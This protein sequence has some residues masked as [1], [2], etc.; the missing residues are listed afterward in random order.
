MLT[1]A[2][3]PHVRRPRERF[4]ISAAIL[5]RRHN[6]PRPPRGGWIGGTAHPFPGRPAKIVSGGKKSRVLQSCA[7]ALKAALNGLPAQLQRRCALMVKFAKCRFLTTLGGVLKLFT[8]ISHT[9]PCGQP[10]NAHNQLFQE[11]RLCS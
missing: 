2:A 1:L 6:T 4:A 3:I 11:G 7:Q 5:A 10:S 8:T 9:S